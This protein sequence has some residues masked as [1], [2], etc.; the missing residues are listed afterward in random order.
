MENRRRYSFNQIAVDSVDLLDLA[1]VNVQEK[2][3][4]TDCCCTELYCVSCKTDTQM[5]VLDQW[6]THNTH[7]TWNQFDFLNTYS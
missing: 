6:F 4:E 3:G 2:A 7:K 1:L 5:H